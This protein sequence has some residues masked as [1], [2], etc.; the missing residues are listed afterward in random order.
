[1]IANTKAAKGLGTA[2]V[3]KYFTRVGEHLNESYNYR[4]QANSVKSAQGVKYFTRLD[5][6]KDKNRQL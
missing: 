3:V 4:R 5:C 1:V 6:V 2:N